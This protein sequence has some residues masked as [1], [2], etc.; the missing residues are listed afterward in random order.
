MSAEQPLVFR[1]GIISS[2]WIASQFVKDLLEDP[3]IRDVH[4]V[5][6]KVVAV[7]SRSAESAQKFIDTHASGD[8]TAKAYGSYAEVYADPD[9]D[10]VYIGTPHAFHYTN[11]KDA[12]LAKKH[13]LVEKPATSNAAEWRSLVAL[14][15]E[16][17][18]FLMEAM[19]TRFHPAALAVRR[20]IDEG[21]LGDIV[22][23]HADLSGDFDI[24][25]IPK[26]HRILDPRL[27]GGALLDLGPYPLVWVRSF[28]F[29]D[30]TSR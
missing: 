15:K 13:V 24:D 9:V 27:G 22:M 12:I 17:N 30:P 8:K 18:V 21:K 2:G 14:A 4:D 28:P 29:S 16:N 3:K 25:N 20:V 6:H 23:V 10:A 7:G 11:S 19:W 1:W 26:T 5:V